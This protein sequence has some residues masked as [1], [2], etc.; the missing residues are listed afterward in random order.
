MKT[1]SIKQKLGLLVGI[2]GIALVAMAILNYTDVSDISGLQKRL[3]VWSNIDMMMNEDIHQP[4]LEICSNIYRYV[5]VQDEA[6]QREVH[7][8]FVVLKRN[9]AAWAGLAPDNNNLQQT[10]QVIQQ[11]LSLLESKFH[12]YA[13][14]HQSVSGNDL[15]D[16]VYNLQNSL[17][18]EM[19][20]FMDN[21]IDPAKEELEN[22]I[23]ANL[24]TMKTIALIA[25]VVG[26]GLTLV[27]LLLVN[28]NISAPLQ[29]LAWFSAQIGAGNLG[30]TLDY[31][32]NDE[33]G[34][35]ADALRLMSDNLKNIVNELESMTEQ[36]GNGN[37]NWRVRYSNKKGV[38]K[39][40]CQGINKMLDAIV[41]PMQEQVKALERMSKGDLSAFITR[42]FKGE[43]QRVVDLINRF[44]QEMNARLG[45]IRSAVKESSSASEQ[46]GATSQT[47][48][49]S[50]QQQG[51]SLEEIS[52]TVE[53]IDSQVKMNA[54]NAQV[55]NN[56]ANETAQTVKRG[57]EQM[58]QMVRAMNEIAEASREVGK[59]IK[60]IDEI[61]F[62]TNLLALNAAVEAARAGQHG[63]GF[64]VVA[65]EVRNLAG[66]SA[67]AAKETADL[68]ENA[69][70]QVN[71]GVELAGRT[72]NVLKE[73]GQ[74]AAKTRDL[75]AE[76][77]T[78][79]QEQATGINQVT[80]AIGEI[81][82]GV[83]NVLQQS[84]ELATAAE[85][86]HDQVRTVL[87]NIERFKLAEENA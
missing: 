5:H 44:L 60:V 50:A 72:A 38:F 42:E 7:N 8:A 48:A 2:M 19:D 26:I 31:R 55:A 21:V 6:T 69:L 57:N 32:Q 37:M 65:Q 58:E 39:D 4:V 70:K 45:K 24:Q 62:Q 73:I 87:E 71:E 74:N 43:H 41:E 52:S 34:R 10:A 54:E 79:S 85:E 76:M 63:K 51:A 59:I 56:L 3:N 27:I 46:V 17:Q 49:S 64:A 78:G 22:E 15:I 35:V 47:L 61:A 67:K 80:R 16:A 77:S 40:L 23:V 33:I 81:N 53:E 66:R 12:A 9:L 36:V 82:T 84:E 75:V 18:A 25:G 28:R 11:K 20:Q 83:Q 13:K 14:N 86:L 30:V 68:I 29:K 1:F